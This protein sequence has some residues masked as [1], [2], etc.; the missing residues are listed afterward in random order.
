MT[1][2]GGMVVL[3]KTPGGSGA[4]TAYMPLSGGVAIVGMDAEAAG[5]DT[6]RML[7]GL[8]GLADLLLDRRRA[9]VERERARGFEASDRL[10]AAILSSLSHELKS[11]IAALRAGPAGFAARRGGHG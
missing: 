7:A 11:L 2:K 3:M 5:L 9:V 4:G 6:L 10:K 8:I 1:I